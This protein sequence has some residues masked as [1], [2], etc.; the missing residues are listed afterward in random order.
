MPTAYLGNCSRTGLLLTLTSLFS[1]KSCSL[2]YSV[3]V[4][5]LQTVPHILEYLFIIL[6]SFRFE[7]D[8]GSNATALPYILFMS[9]I[10]SNDIIH[11]IFMC[12]MGK[13]ELDFWLVIMDC[14]I[15]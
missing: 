2:S 6:Y 4:L 1:D 15:M 13:R 8:I 7:E 10:F 14:F 11:G 3:T 12:L 5:G 9:F